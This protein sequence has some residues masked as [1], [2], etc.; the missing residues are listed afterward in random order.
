M[1][2][3]VLKKYLQNNGSVN[4]TANQMY[5]H[6]NTINYKLKKIEEILS[7]PECQEYISD[8]IIKKSY[9]EVLDETLDVFAN[10][11]EKF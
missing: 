4:D 6:R 1:M 10:L 8:E 5:V 7:D 9:V 2:T 3:D 11:Y